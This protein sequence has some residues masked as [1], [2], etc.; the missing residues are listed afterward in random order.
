MAT[1]GGGTPGSLCLG[2][3]PVGLFANG[4]GISERTVESWVVADLD[5]VNLEEL[6]QAAGLERGSPGLLS[7]L[8][9][10]EGPGFVRR[11]RGAFAVAVWDRLRRQLLL[12][13]DHFGMRRL[14]YSTSAHGTSFSSR[15][16]ALRAGSGAPREVSLDAMYSYLNFRFIPAPETP[17]AGVHRLPPGHTL[18]VGPGYSKV[19]PFWDMAYPEGNCRR[20]RTASALYR[21]THQAVREALDDLPLKKCGAFLS[22]GTDSS[23]VVGL[24]TH[25]TGEQINAFSI[26]FSSDRYDE[27]QHAALTARHFDAHHYTRIVSADDALEVLP[28]LVAA[29]DEPFGNNSALGTL[30][31]AQMARDEGVT[32]LLAGDGGD[33]IFGGNERYRTDGIFS[34]YSRLP[35]VLRHGLLEPILL[36][37]PASSPGILGRGQRYILRARIPNPRRFYSYEFYVAQNVGRLLHP[38]FLGSIVAE[39]P[40]AALERHFDRVRA[41]SELNRLLY[42]D[43]KLTLGDNDLLKV[44]RTGELAGVDVRFPLLALPLV[45]FTGTWPA[46]FKVR[47]LEKR[48]LFKRAF[49]SLL[50]PQTLT[51]KKQGFGVPTAEWI[52]SHAGFRELAR[53]TLL[54]P[55]AAQRGYFRPGALEEVFALHVADE[56]PF[57]GDLLWSILMLELWH[58]RHV[59]RRETS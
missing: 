47:G 41:S 43:L 51:K 6:H 33:E 50:P 40:W 56:T 30:F 32:H 59:D 11:L 35:A 55:R 42:L 3:E 10:L 14:H 49:R 8:Y 45:E 12:A 15:L 29:Y 5:L 53:D 58:R 54:S 44:T 16:G 9:A 17:F 22:G 39:A 23:T 34:R 2:E 18:V 31:C 38:D 52:K 24:M 57:Y 7:R 27:L 1:A 25:L 37:L 20:D 26:G 19:E 28:N 48:H 21:L 36:G 13:V 46:E 4:R